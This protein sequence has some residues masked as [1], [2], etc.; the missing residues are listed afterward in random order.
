[1]EEF[2]DGD[3]KGLN[4]NEGTNMLL[5]TDYT[6]GWNIRH[7]EYHPKVIRTQYT[8]NLDV[9]SPIIYD[10]VSEGFQELVDPKLSFD[11]K[12]FYLNQFS[13]G[14]RL[15]IYWPLAWTPLRPYTIFLDIIARSVNRT[16]VGLP[17]ARNPELIQ[18]AIKHTFVIVISGGFL[19]FFPEILKTCVLCPCS[20]FGLIYINLKAY[21][22]IHQIVLGRK[23]QDSI[24]D[25]HTVYRRASPGPKITTVA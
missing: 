8:R 24:Q 2:L 17:L 16:F 19:K 23:C 4:Q 21:Q 15:S 25:S 9:L 13:H 3:E 22:C 1:L 10:E 5:Q 18:V 6:M 12:H 20:F 11:S 7:T 14:M